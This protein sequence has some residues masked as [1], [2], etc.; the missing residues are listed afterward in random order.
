MKSE[1]RH[2]LKTNELQRLVTQ[3]SDSLGPLWKSHGK[4][5]AVGIGGIAL[6]AVLISWWI[7]SSE[8]ESAAGWEQLFTATD[9]ED[10]GELQNVYDDAQEGKVSR[11]VGAWAKLTEAKMHLALGTRYLLAGKIPGKKTGEDVPMQEL[12][13]AEK[14]FATLLEDLEADGNPSADWENRI[15]EQALFGMAQTQEAL[16]SGDTAP[17][18]EAY[19]AL[20]EEYPNSIY[21]EVAEQRLKTLRKADTE[22]FYAWFAERPPVADGPPSFPND[23]GASN[24][25]SNSLFDI[26]FLPEI[27]EMLKLED[28][29]LETSSTTP[30]SDATSTPA[31]Q[32]DAAAKP[33][34]PP[35]DKAKPDPAPADKPKPDKE[36]A[37]KPPADKPP[38]DKAKPDKAPADKAPRSQPVP[39]GSKS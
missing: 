11:S 15:R 32:P 21:T 34:K 23:Q 6:V 12:R 28:Q 16:C 35:A 22:D 27:P 17:A 31:D 20:K 14:C 3:L 19:D 8:A 25:N 5:A 4:A 24:A 2:R 29:P 18:I 37:D 38:A 39:P 26:P 13:D 7:S 36:R 10:I 9:S 30:D 33:D 1:E